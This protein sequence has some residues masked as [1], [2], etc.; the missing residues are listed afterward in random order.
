MDDFAA[1][2]DTYKLFFSGEV[3]PA[4]STVAVKTL[5]GNVK[6]EIE[7]IALQ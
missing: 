3:K 4:R 7:C 5:P 2:N 1:V 6:I